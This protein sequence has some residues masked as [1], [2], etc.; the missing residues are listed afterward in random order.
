MK[1]QCGVDLNLYMP[2]NFENHLWNLTTDPNMINAPNDY[3]EL[4]Q[5]AVRVKNS[6]LLKIPN[7]NHGPRLMRRYLQSGA[8]IAHGLARSNIPSF[9]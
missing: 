8:P 5:R 7:S 4:A 9:Y 2:Y 1:P 3:L 6:Y